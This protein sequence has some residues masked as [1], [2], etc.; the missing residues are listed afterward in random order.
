MSIVEASGNNSKSNDN[1]QLSACGH[2][3]QLLNDIIRA[4]SLK[5][6]VS[7]L[8]ECFNSVSHCT[9]EANTTNGCIL[10]CMPDSS[11]VH[12]LILL[13]EPVPVISFQNV[14][15]LIEVSSPKMNLLCDGET[16]FGFGYIDS[17]NSEQTC[18]IYF[19]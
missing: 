5:G 9:Y 11:S 19:E 16:I 7:K 12:Q 18:I 4:N 14:R 2:V 17:K 8:I 6:H 3:T 13:K 1:V 15:K 10:L